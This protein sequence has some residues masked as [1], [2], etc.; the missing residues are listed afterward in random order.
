MLSNEWFYV[1][2]Q[3]RDSDIAISLLTAME[4]FADADVLPI[5]GDSKPRFAIMLGIVSGHQT[6]LKNRFMELQGFKNGG[7]NFVRAPQ[8]GQIQDDTDISP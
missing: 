2:S 5:T 6:G 1:M 7:G 4:Q 8:Y 3:F